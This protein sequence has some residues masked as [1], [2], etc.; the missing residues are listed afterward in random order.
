MWMTSWFLRLESGIVESDVVILSCS[1]IEFV[2][3]YML[4]EVEVEL[5]NGAKEG[6]SYA[7]NC[8]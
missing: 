6:S 2:C 3:V 1:T 5:T 8:C 7:C 4:L